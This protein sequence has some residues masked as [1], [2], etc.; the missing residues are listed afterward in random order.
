MAYFSIPLPQ[1]TEALPSDPKILLK[2]DPNR[3]KYNR[4]NVY[5]KL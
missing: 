2:P 1:P 3:L 4:N 5:V